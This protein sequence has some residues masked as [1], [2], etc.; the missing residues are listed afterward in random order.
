MMVR[1]TK[2]PCMWHYKFSIG[3]GKPGVLG[4][5][6]LRATKKAIWKIAIDAAG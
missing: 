1:F 4:E 5:A 2:P 6:L 3:S